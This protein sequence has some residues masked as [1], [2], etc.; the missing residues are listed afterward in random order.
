VQDFLDSMSK[1]SNMSEAT[2]VA[3]TEACIDARDDRTEVS[4]FRKGIAK[5]FD[6]VCVVEGAM[7]NLLVRAKDQSTNEK[8]AVQS[9]SRTCPNVL[10][11]MEVLWEIKVLQH[12]V[13][14]PHPTSKS[15][16]TNLLMKAFTS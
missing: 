1:I 4:A 8:V 3:S 11:T 15:S 16:S 6:P 10:N 7:E 14:N 13:A 9:L 5:K 2:D 12:L